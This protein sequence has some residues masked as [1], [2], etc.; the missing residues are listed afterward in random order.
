MKL[1]LVLA[2]LLCLLSGCVAVPTGVT[3]VNNFAVERYMGKWYEIAR[4]DH[5]FERGLSHVTA[6]YQLRADGGVS[7]VNKGY[8]AS[9]GEWKTAEGKAF[10][11]KTPTLGYLKV[12]FFGPFYGAYVVAELDHAGYHYALVSGPNTN[13]LW[14]LART[15]TLPP[16]I[17]Q[18][19]VNK[20]QSL[21][22]DTSKLIYVQQ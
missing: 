3:P 11:V 19:L 2:T 16:A 14:L 4:L 1:K 5:R 7:V 6:N 15:P 10:F 21:G 20:A 12:S 8:K 17:R 9:S 18:Q 13:Y 22:F